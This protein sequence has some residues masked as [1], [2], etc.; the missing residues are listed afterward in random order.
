MKCRFNK[1]YEIDP[2]A[3]SKTYFYLLIITF[4]RVTEWPLLKSWYLL[5][6]TNMSCCQNIIILYV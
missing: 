4:F 2:V 3:I 5:Y 1:S 6:L